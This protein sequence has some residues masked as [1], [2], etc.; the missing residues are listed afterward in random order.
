MLSIKAVAKKLKVSDSAIYKMIRE[1]RNVGA[2]FF[3]IPGTGYRVDETEWNFGE[4][5]T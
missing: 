1:K 5:A 2:R 4:V 3:Y